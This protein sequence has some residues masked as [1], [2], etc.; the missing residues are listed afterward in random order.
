[1]LSVE[2]E[3][4]SSTAPS[5]S[6]RQGDWAPGTVTHEATAGV[7]TALAGVEVMHTHNARTH[8]RTRART[9]THIHTYICVPA[10]HMTTALAAVQEEASS[11]ALEGCGSD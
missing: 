1:M 10:T 3:C 7:M 9:H 8:A 4:L 6:Q 11:E 2:V 5:Q